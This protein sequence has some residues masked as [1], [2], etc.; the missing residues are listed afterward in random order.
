L[1][2][3]NSLSTGLASLSDT[4]GVT[5]IYFVDDAAAADAV[6][7][8]EAEVAGGLSLALSLLFLFEISFFRLK[9]PK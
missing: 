8:A 3:K 4:T 5:A 9:S 2:I 7:R 1:S 6:S